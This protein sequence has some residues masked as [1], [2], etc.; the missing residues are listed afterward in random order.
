[1][2]RLAD[3]RRIPL[4]RSLILAL[5]LALPAAVVLSAADAAAQQRGQRFFTRADT[6]GDGAVSQEEFAAAPLPAPFGK[7]TPKQ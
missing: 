6:N 3:M 1:M 2:V 5:A 7:L 4:N